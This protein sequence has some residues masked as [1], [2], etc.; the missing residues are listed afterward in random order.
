MALKN[1]TLVKQQ[2]FVA[3]YFS[4]QSGS[5]LKVKFR[6]LDAIHGTFFAGMCITE[7]TNCL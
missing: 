5:F 6:S 3:L 4:T 1:A 7:A 2:E